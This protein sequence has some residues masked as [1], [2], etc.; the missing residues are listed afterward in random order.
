MAAR[1]GSPRQPADV[2]VPATRSPVFRVLNS[3]SQV[4]RTRAIAPRV[5]APSSPPPSPSVRCAK[6]ECVLGMGRARGAAH[7]WPSLAWCLVTL[8]NLPEGLFFLRV[9]EPFVGLDH[10]VTEG[11]PPEVLPSPPPC[12]WSTG[13]CVCASARACQQTHPVRASRRET[14]ARERTHHSHAS[15]DGPATD[16]S[17]RASLAQVA[18]VVL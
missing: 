18:L 14:R 3:R 12:G 1:E 5:A 13:F 16:P 11:L 9:L 10:G 2:R 6:K 4:S 7:R 17:L 8:M 15:H